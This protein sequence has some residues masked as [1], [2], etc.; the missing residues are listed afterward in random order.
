MRESIVG[1]RDSRLFQ[2][3]VLLPEQF[4][5]TLRRR[6]PREPEIR[7][8][9]AILEDAIDCFQKHLWAREHKARQLFED[10][11]AWILSEEREWPFSFE[12]I[13]ELLDLNPE[14]LRNGLLAWKEHQ[15]AERSRGKIVHLKPYVAL[16]SDDELELRK[17]SAS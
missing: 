10:S 16:D 17:A 12:N 7:L 4:F 9:I 3:D 13:C 6:G 15:L 5:S 8:V 2:P 11:E 14:Y 1:E